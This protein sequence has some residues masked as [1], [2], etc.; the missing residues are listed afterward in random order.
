M[1]SLYVVSVQSLQPSV[2]WLP[3]RVKRFVVSGCADL[4]RTPK[5]LVEAEDKCARVSKPC[6]PQDVPGGMLLD[7]YLRTSKCR[8]S[9]CKPCAHVCTHV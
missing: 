7:S 9:G 8:K 2:L 5:C 3:C 1:A 6:W 4:L